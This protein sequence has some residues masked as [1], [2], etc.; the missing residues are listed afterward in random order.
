MKSAVKKIVRAS[1]KSAEKAMANHID[2]MKKKGWEVDQEFAGDCGCSYEC[3][4][5]FYKNCGATISK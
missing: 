2:K 1:K 3:I 5:W 4:T